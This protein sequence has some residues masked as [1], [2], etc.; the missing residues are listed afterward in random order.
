MLRTI[1]FV[2]SSIA[3]WA[4]MPVAE[5][6]VRH[7]AAL[8]VAVLADPRVIG[9]AMFM[10]AGSAFVSVLAVALC[11]TAGQQDRAARHDS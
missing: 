11:V 7:A 8:A 10:A 2:A 1:A 4:I 3:L 9:A 6:V 5:A